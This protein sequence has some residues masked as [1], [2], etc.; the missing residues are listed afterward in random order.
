MGALRATVSSGISYMFPCL[1]MTEQCFQEYSS[2]K[3]Y[4]SE[5]PDESITPED[6]INDQFLITALSNSVKG[7][8]RSQCVQKVKAGGVILHVVNLF[9]RGCVIVTRAKYLR[10]DPNVLG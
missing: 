2:G 8:G 4:N 6:N 1:P 10:V 3:E 5:K 7:Q 9:D